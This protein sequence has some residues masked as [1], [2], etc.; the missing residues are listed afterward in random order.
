MVVIRH[1]NLAIESEKKGSHLVHQTMFLV[2][3]CVQRSVSDLPPALETDNPSISRWI[4]FRPAWGEAKVL[5]MPAVAGDA[6]SAKVRKLRFDRSLV[7]SIIT[8]RDC[9]PFS[10]TIAPVQF[11][12]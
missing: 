6:R 7:G 12:Q 3:H 8:W 9:R 11:M 1:A 2:S 10:M 5:T 4:P